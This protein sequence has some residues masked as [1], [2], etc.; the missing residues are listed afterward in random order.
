MRKLLIV[1]D[2]RYSYPPAVHLIGEID[3]VRVLSSQA[4]EFLQKVSGESAG[5]RR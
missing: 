1:T 4:C 3:G 2:N 5:W